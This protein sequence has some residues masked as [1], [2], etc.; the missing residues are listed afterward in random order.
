MSL[1]T[2]SSSIFMSLKCALE[3]ARL[4][5]RQKPAWERSL[6]RLA[7]TIAHELS[8]ALSAMGNRQQARV[9]FQWVENRKFENGTFW[10]GFTFPDM[11]V[12]PAEKLT[13]NNAAA[14]LA[15]DALYDLTPTG[16]LFDHAFWR[17]AGLS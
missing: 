3:I 5:G 15:A 16:R 6:L 17:K 2:G 13:W 1:L 7:E 12:W 9:V 8:L 4:I 14:L 10:T 11:T